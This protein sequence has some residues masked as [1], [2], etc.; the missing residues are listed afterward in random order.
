[1]APPLAPY[2][3]G[4]IS[5]RSVTHHIKDEAIFIFCVAGPKTRDQNHPHSS[6]ISFAE[7]N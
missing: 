6:R 5:D 4:L 2:L 3:F 1:M 7:S